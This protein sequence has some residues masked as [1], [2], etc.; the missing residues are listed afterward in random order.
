MPSP[1]PGMNPYLEEERLWS[2]F[3][4]Q[5]VASLLQSLMPG[6]GERSRARVVQ[7]EY[8]T[9][10]ALFTSIVREQHQED[11]LEIRQRSDGRLLTLVDVV[12]PGNKCTPQ[13][14]AAYLATRAE[15]RRA[16]AS[17]VEVD[18]VL[19]GEPTLDYS[20]ESLPEWD[21]VV[22]VTRPAQAERYEIYTSTLQKRLPRFRLPLGPDERDTVVD[23]QAAFLRAFERGDF[24]G[25]IDYARDP[26]VP[27]EESDRRWLG[28]L[29]Q[30]EHLR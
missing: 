23:L 21:Y 5:L 12:S 20:R 29:L 30:Q 9:E 24:A 10:Q 18:L 16:R 25:Q 28:E 3:H 22:S 8:T 13:G 26:A 1:F 7:R 6:L 19:Q 2:A 17:L 14:R 27:L 15:G 4:R 11:F